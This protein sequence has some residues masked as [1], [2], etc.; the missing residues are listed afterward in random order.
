MSTTEG[1]NAFA[2]VPARVD[3]GSLL[4]S[5]LS[6]PRGED[7]SPPRG[8]R[9]GMGLGELPAWAGALDPSAWLFL[10][11]Q[12]SADSRRTVFSGLKRL[13]QLL[14]PS[15][16]WCATGRLELLALRDKLRGW[17]TVSY[18]NKLLGYL[19]GVL[20]ERVTLGELDPRHLEQLSDGLHVRGQD[21][22][23]GRRLGTGEIGELYLTCASGNNSVRDCAILSL[24]LGAG[25][26]VSEA[27]SLATSG[28]FAGYVTVTGK[29][30]KVRRVP[31]GTNARTALGRW[32]QIRDPNLPTVFGIGARGIRAMLERRRKRAGVESF[33]THDCRRTFVSNLLAAGVDLATVQQL[34]GH[35]D[36]RT[37]SNYDRRDGEAMRAAVNGLHLPIVGAL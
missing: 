17:Y 33:T 15:D 13:V 6:T 23:P 11:R 5:P 26:R 37:T 20:K 24:M 36:P 18:A 19:R 28:V 25:L 21:A 14:G 35:A 29:G 27:A 31:L 16:G 3:S 22:R 7:E 9:A 12:Q 8:L 10:A 34:A 1:S 4:P 30:N 32:M 2:R